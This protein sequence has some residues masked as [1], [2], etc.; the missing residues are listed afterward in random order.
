[1]RQYFEAQTSSFEGANGWIFWT[2]KVRWPVLAVIST[3]SSYPLPPLPISTPLLPHSHNAIRCD[4]RR[5]QMSGVTPRASKAD[6]SHGT[7]RSDSILMSA[8]ELNNVILMSWS[9]VN[10]Q[11]LASWWRC[12]TCRQQGCAYIL[13]ALR[14]LMDILAFVYLFVRFLNTAAPFPIGLSMSLCTCIA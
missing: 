9:G 4:G 7:R 1:M 6:G 13:P 8:G 3:P 5:R 10:S 12:P 14:D 11:S 2:W